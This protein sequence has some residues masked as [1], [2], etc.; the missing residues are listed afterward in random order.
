MNRPRIPAA[1]VIDRRRV[2][3]VEF[4]VDHPALLSVLVT[5]PLL[6]VVDRPEAFI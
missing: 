2:A 5:L 6:S 4:A 3:A 1:R